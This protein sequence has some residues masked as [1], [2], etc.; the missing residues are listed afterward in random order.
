MR[1]AFIPP[2]K[3]QRPIGHGIASTDILE[4][5]IQNANRIICS[6]IC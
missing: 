1:P 6:E 2:A 3:Y 4:Q 5:Y